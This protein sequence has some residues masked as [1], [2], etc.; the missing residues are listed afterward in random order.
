[1][2]RFRA[3]CANSGGRRC[4]S[5]ARREVG[6]SAC[7]RLPQ[8]WAG[9][10]ADCQGKTMPPTGIEPEARSEPATNRCRRPVL[11]AP[12]GSFR[13]ASRI[14]D[15]SRRRSTS[16]PSFG[17]SPL[18]TSP[19]SRSRSGA[20][21][22]GRVRACTGWPTTHDSGE[23]RAERRS[24]AFRDPPSTASTAAAG[25]TNLVAPKNSHHKTGTPGHLGTRT[26]DCR[27]R[28]HQPRSRSDEGTR[29]SFRCP[30]S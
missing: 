13:S 30:S 17:L 20:R 15:T 16:F 21:E 27:A 29:S 25:L 3:A 26:S 28:A 14:S 12:P 11:T 7:V 5:R 8:T 9:G 1:V 23:P 22:A 18:H 4:P 6:P 2:A 24:R 10:T 19:S